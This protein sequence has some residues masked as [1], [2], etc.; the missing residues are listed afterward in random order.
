[1]IGIGAA[2]AASARVDAAAAAGTEV[3]DIDARRSGCVMGGP[4]ARRGERGE[5]GEVWVRS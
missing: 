2:L 1:M 3:R 5:Q 4:G